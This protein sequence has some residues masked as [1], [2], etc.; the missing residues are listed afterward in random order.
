MGIFNN[1]EAVAFFRENGYP[2]GYNDGMLAWLREV[3]NTTHSSL[4]DLLSRYLNEYGDRFN[5]IIPGRSGVQV[6][7]TSPAA[8]FTAITPTDGGSGTVVLTSGGAHGLTAAKAVGRSLFITGGNGWTEGF[9][10]I[11]A[12]DLDTTGVAVTITAEWDAG[13]GAPDVALAGTTIN[14]AEI[15][16]P[17]LRTDSIVKVDATWG[18]EDSAN[19]KNGFINWG[20]VD[21]YSTNITNSVVLH[22]S[23]VLIHNRGVTNSQIGSMAETNAN[24]TGRASTAIGEGS[25]DTSVATTLKL[26]GKLTAADEYVSLERYLVTVFL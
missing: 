8:T 26:R 18:A 21:F 11:T 25:F 24:Q 10:P 20:G 2:S 23:S 7:Y 22:P 3:Y 13:L 19:L 17:I 16:I 1:D 5:M 4:P 6:L 12:I 14:L 9:Y 15:T